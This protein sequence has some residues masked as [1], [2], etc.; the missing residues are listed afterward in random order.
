MTRRK[1]RIL[2]EL[3]DI[4]EKIAEPEAFLKGSCRIQG[5]V[6]DADHDIQ[7]NT[8]SSQV[9]RGFSMHYVS[10]KVNVRAESGICNVC[11]TPCSSCM[12]FNRAASFM[13][14]KSEFSDETSQGKAASRCS[15]NDA[16]VPHPSKSR[17]CSDG[18]PTFSETSNLL[19]ASSSHDS[20]SE[21]AESKATL[22][23]FDA[24]DASED[25]EMLPKLSSGGTGGEDQP[26]SKVQWISQTAVTSLQGCLASDLGQRTYSNQFEEQKGLECHGDN[27]SCVSGANEANVAVVDLNVDINRKNLPCNLASVSSSSP[28]GTDITLSAQ[29]TSSCIDD[30]NCKIEESRNNSRWPS[31]VAIESLYK[32]STNAATPPVLTPKPEPLDIPSSKDVYPI[33]VSRKVQSPYSHSQN[34]N[35]VS[36]DTDGK[37]LEEDSSSHHREEPSECSTEHVKSSLGQVVESNSA[38][39]KTVPLK[40]AKIVPQ[41]ENGK[42]S[43][44]RSNS[45]G[46]SM[47]VHPCL[48]SE[49]ALVNGDPSTETINCF[50]KNE[51]VD[52]PCALAKVADMLEPPLQSEPVDESD[53][54][55]IVEDDVKVCDICG[56]AGREDLLAFCSRCSDGAEHTYCMR[57]MLDK[58]PEGDWMCEEC[59]LKEDTEKQKQDE[60][61]TTSGFSKEPY[62]SERSQNSG[63]ASTVSSKMMMKVEL[64]A[65]DSE[66]NRSAKVIS[67][68]LLSVK[69]HLDNS[70]VASAEKRQ[71]FDTSVGSPKAS[72]PSKKPLLSRESS[73]KSLDKGKVKTIHKVASFGSHFANNSHEIAHSPTTTGPN[74]SRIQSRLQSPRGTL[75]KSKSFNML[76]L[77]SKVKLVQEDVSQKKKVAGNCVIG[78]MKKEGL[79]RTLGKSMSF[80]S[81]N[82]G[83][84]NVTESKVKIL[85]PNLSRVEELKGLKQAKE[86]NLIE[87]KNSFKSDR[88]LVSSP[89]A[90]SSMSTLK[91]DQKINSR[92]E[93]ASFLSSATNFRDPK[94]AQADGKLKTSSKPAN[95]ANKGS[96]IRNA[97]AASNEVKRQS[98]VGALSSNGRCSSTEQKPSQVSP[99]DEPTSSSSVSA[100]RACGKH[101]TLLQ[102]G[103]PQSRESL[104]QGAKSREPPHLGH[105]RQSISVGGQSARCQKCKGMGHVAQSCPVSNSRVSVL[106]ASAEKISKEMMDKSCK[107]KEAVEPKI[108]KRP[109]ICR[110]N[111]SP[112]QLDELSMSSTDLST[113]VSKD[114]L[115]ASSSCLRNNSSQG[116]SDGQEIVRN[117][118]ADI[119]R[120]TTVDNVKQ[121]AIHLREEI[122]SPQAGESDPSFSV[123]ANKTSSSIRNLPFLESSVAAPSGISV[124][125]EHDFLWQGC[126]EVQRNGILPDLC[127][128]IQ[129]H[130][131]TC[132]S[133]KVPEVV[134]KFP[135][136]VLLEEV[137]CLST[138]P[139]QFD[140]NH[141]TE[142]NVALYF[143]AKDIE[144]YE[145]Y[146]K[147]LVDKMIRNDLALK[148]NFDG[149]ELLIFPSNKLPDKSQRWN[150]LFFLW[151][152]FR[153]R[154]PN[155]LEQTP[156]PQK[157]VSQANLDTVFA[158]Q[159]LPASVQPVHKQLHLPGQMEDLSASNKSFCGPEADKSTAS[160]EL[161]FLSSGRLDGDC[162]PNISSLDHKYT[163]SHKNFDQQGSG[164]DNNSMSRIHTGDE[165]LS[166][167]SNSNTLKEQT[168]KEG[169]Q[170]GKIQTCTQAT[171]Q[172]GNLYKGKSVPVEL[173]NSLDRQDDSSCSLKTPPFSTSLSQGFGVVGGTDKQK[174][175]ER[176]QDEIRDEMKI[177]KEMM[178]PDGLMDIGTALKRTLKSES[179]D[180]GNCN[181]ESN[182]RKRLHMDSALMIQQV[183]GETSSS[184]SRATLWMGEDHL[185]VGGESE[186]KKIK[187]CSSVVYGCNS[188]SEQNSFNERFPPQ[189]HDVAS[190]FPINEQQ[191]YGEPYERME[192]LR[193]TERHFFPLDLGS[194]KDCKPR[195]TSV[196]S[197]ILSSN[198]EDLLGS[199]A[200]N[201]ELALGAERRPPKQGMLPWLVGTADKRNTRDP[202]A[203]KKVDDDGV[204]ASLSLSLAF[205]F[206]S[207][208]HTVKPVSITEQ[209]L[210]EAHRVNTSLFLF[211]GFSDN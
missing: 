45:C 57:L 112:E 168:N 46:A 66:G 124:I 122:I 62:L 18:Q 110:K 121:Y 115:S 157:K 193:T 19:S 31:T 131:S 50:V 77:K 83:C 33:R 211:G 3:Y 71:A 152:V 104:N 111:R 210:P 39:G 74:P 183:S 63:G 105:S 140:D 198:N 107:L 56:D 172:N 144:S 205:P 21:N 166:T 81:E 134:K 78:D 190:G 55:D 102:D 185:L 154:R 162:E 37:D 146:Y 147:C 192:N 138:W 22:K 176:M 68:S 163:S 86:Q 135:S 180:K 148:G 10:G 179:L 30:L 58:V 90:V 202:V 151:G 158:H 53:G 103:L 28:G 61:E 52:K 100:D 88:P 141:A 204:S 164:L 206:S 203:N 84:L 150:M 160:V 178:S 175:P 116:T 76:N 200:P 167:K 1:E 155:C 125:P 101:D 2:K 91:N 98:V 142:D 48:E 130:L 170:E 16:N 7:M 4:T 129:A 156:G 128:G 9:E 42:A 41:L 118:A 120:I 194:V 36:H 199:E 207:K 73:F 171:T 72:S 97:L 12:H 92:A 13:G 143:F 109:G 177:Q 209:L 137:P 6:D 29:N 149:T 136:K 24:S 181:W 64:K 44:S 184:R 153:G 123:D 197:Q 38:T 161:P 25:V 186:M 70:E 159:N 65:P 174:I 133:P 96:D 34:G 108:L 182:S 99:K 5:P 94:P 27:I 82:L 113:E 93:N 139:R 23:T 196:S 59:K 43:L 114:Q 40:C 95:L 201:L 106:E 145:R 87:R 20:I 8:G 187:R 54:S 89:R 165:Q 60:V 132:A 173:N 191:Q 14:S 127:D 80:K 32:R 51:Q 11:A 195:D 17:A 208:E 67:S 47:K 188:S 119:S 49:P 26:I 126:F 15:L 79:V 69:R 117:S 35:S 85:S 169:M 75:L 189:V